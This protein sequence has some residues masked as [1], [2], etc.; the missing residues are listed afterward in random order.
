MLLIWGAQDVGFPLEMG[1]SAH[2]QLP[3]SALVALENSA[4]APYLERP[5]A[6]N[7]VVLDFLGRDLGSWKQ[8]DVVYYR[9]T[10]TAAP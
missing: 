6:F 9:P 5:E 1:R 7:R 4:H 3:G 2:E 10:S 8:S